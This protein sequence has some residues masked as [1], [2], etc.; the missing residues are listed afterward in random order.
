MPPV[1]DLLDYYVTLVQ[2]QD[3]FSLNFDQRQKI[4]LLLL[5]D[6]FSYKISMIDVCSM[7][8]FLVFEPDQTSQAEIELEYI[9]W[10]CSELI[11]TEEQNKV[12]EERQQ[13]QNDLLKQME[14]YLTIHKAKVIDELI[15]GS[16]QKLS[17]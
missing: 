1:R 8:Q 14:E 2:V 3:F 5:H 10:C 9:I 15:I 7:A 4:L 13:P 6:Y 11:D 12:Y 16:K 17:C